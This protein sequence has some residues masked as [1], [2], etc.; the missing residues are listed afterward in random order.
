LTQYLTWRSIFFLMAPLGGVALVLA[1]TKLRLEW[2]EAKGQRFDLAGSLLYGLALICLMQGVSGLPESKGL[3]LSGLGLAG[4]GIFVW[5]EQRVESPIFEIKLLRT[6]RVFAFSSLAALIHYCATFAVTFLLSL[7]L[8]NVRGFSPQGAGLLLM[9]QPVVMALLS[10][11]AGRISD[12]VQPRVVASCGMAITCV[13]LILFSFLDQNTSV[14]YI[15]AS[16]CLLGSGYGIFSSPN[17]NAIMSSVET[18]FLGIA[19]GA[20]ATMRIL[21]QMVSLGTATCLFALFIG[22][23]QIT[24]EYYPALVKSLHV[25]FMIFAGLCLLGVLASLARGKLNSAPAEEESGRG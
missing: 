10:P 6:N 1:W 16:L 8:Q 25:A 7:Y 17:V 20:V 5:W 13:G 4:L 14:G 3:A 2:A 22:H 24:P 19:A 11:L 23:V 21:G 12:T 18:R 9:A 15:V